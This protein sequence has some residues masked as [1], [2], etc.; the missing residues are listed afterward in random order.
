MLQPHVP[1]YQTFVRPSVCTYDCLDM[2]VR[3]LLSS[4]LSMRAARRRVKVHEIDFVIEVTACL[5]HVHTHTHIHILSIGKL[6]VGAAQ[7]QQLLAPHIVCV[8]STLIANSSSNTH[9][10]TCQR[11]NIIAFQWSVFYWLL[12]Y[13]VV[14]VM[15]FQLMWLLLLFLLW[16]AHSLRRIVVVS[17]LYMQRTHARQCCISPQNCKSPLQHFNSNTHTYKHTHILA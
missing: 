10:H 11:H 4:L 15:L 14:N 2:L 3:G 16:L 6:L 1:P 17:R 7:R 13:V 8:C 12:S 9:T 5:I